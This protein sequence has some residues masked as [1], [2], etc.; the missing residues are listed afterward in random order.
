M[1]LEQ[2]ACAVVAE[3]ASYAGHFEAV[4]ETVVDEDATREGEHLRLVL[5][6]AEGCREDETVV[7]ALELRAVVVALQVAVL[8]P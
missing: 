8:L 7:V 2:E 3:G 1:A 5:Q 6:A 4:G